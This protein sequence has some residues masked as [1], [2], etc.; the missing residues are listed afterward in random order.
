MARYRIVS[1]AAKRE[2]AD[3]RYNSNDY[4]A[5]KL[6]NSFLRSGT[7]LPNGEFFLWHGAKLFILHHPQITIKLRQKLT[8]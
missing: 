6:C 4:R 5:V 8:K 3:E 1:E 7:P 2:W